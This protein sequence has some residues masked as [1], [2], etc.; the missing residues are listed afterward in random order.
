MTDIDF[1]FIQEADTRVGLIVDTHPRYGQERLPLQ[2]FMESLDVSSRVI[3]YDYN[4]HRGLDPQSA[5][6]TW[7]LASDYHGPPTFWG[8]SDPAPTCLKCVVDMFLEQLERVEPDEEASSELIIVTPGSIADSEADVQAMAQNMRAKSVSLRVVIFPY[9]RE[10]DRS[11]AKIAAVRELVSLAGGT[12]HLVVSHEQTANASAG[13]ALRMGERLSFQE[14]FDSFEDENSRFRHVMIKKEIFQASAGEPIKFTFSLD[15][16]LFDKDMVLVTRFESDAQKLSYDRRYYLKTKSDQLIDTK[17]TMFISSRSSSFEVPLKEPNFK[18]GQWTLH[19]TT[20]KNEAVT[21]VAYVVVPRHQKPITGECWLSSAPFSINAGQPLAIYVSLTQD[22]NKLVQEADLDAT[23]TDDAGQKVMPTAVRLTDDGLASPDITRGDGI[24][25][26]LLFVERPG[27]YHVK[28]NAHGADYRTK[29]HEGFGNEPR[30][31]ADGFGSMVPAPNVN[32]NRHTTTNHLHREIDCGFFYVGSKI[33]KD[34]FAVRITDL[35]VKKVDPAARTVTVGFT[36]PEHDKVGKYEFKMFRS[37]DRTKIMKDFDNV[38]ALLEMTHAIYNRPNEMT[39]NVSSQYA[40]TYHIAIKTFAKGAQASDSKVSNVASFFMV[41][42]P[43]L[44]A[45]EGKRNKHSPGRHPDDSYP[46]TDFD[47]TTDPSFRA[48]SL[49]G[50][51]TW[52]IIVIA[53]ASLIFL[54]LLVACL[55]CLCG[56]K[57]RKDAKDNE[58]Q[59]GAPTKNALN[60]TGNGLSN[61][62]IQTTMNASHT[63]LVPSEKGGSVHGLGNISSLSERNVN[64]TSGVSELNAAMSPV[65][66]W[67]ADVLLGHY[68]LV[69]QA[70]ARNEIPPVMRVED[71]PEAGSST[72]ASSNPSRESGSYD[73]GAFPNGAHQDWR[74]EN[75]ASHSPQQYMAA[76]QPN[77]YQANMYGEQVQYLDQQYYVEPMPQNDVTD[78]QWRASYAPRVETPSD[79]D[80]RYSL[81]GALPRRVGNAVSQ[82]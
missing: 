9:V 22:F 77:M 27:F 60:G 42:D 4:N 46:G 56:S 57:R 66:S 54:V 52:H 80:P 26:Q 35:N 32:S 33:S 23:L 44:V 49:A 58:S 50:L 78:G 1:K 10:D 59:Y 12:M 28:V 41:A 76:N 64:A 34:D 25:S 18:S 62:T 70:R 69:Q 20:D 74:Y 53:A 65:Q 73:E 71:L 17:N 47:Y 45:N 63:N 61:L 38:G 55:V 48:G 43:Q 37:R 5:P 67:P 51:Q 14:A 7:K 30:M 68:G 6:P 79:Y 40:D 19:Y 2:R 81:A 21:G 72:T 11:S 82:V 75:M 31:L 13:G 8:R 24:Y 16:T 29:M 3:I 39:F 15:S 36:A